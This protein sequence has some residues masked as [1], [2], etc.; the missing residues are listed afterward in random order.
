MAMKINIL[1]ELLKKLHYSAP[2]RVKIMGIVGVFVCLLGLNVIVDIRSYMSESLSDQL[3]KRATA[4]GKEVASESINL[5]LV[6]DIFSLYENAKSV[7][8]NNDDLRYVLILD[9]NG[10]LV[11]HTFGQGI[12]AGL[13]E[14]RDINTS[15][16]RSDV[17][18]IDSEEGVLLDV[19]VP[20]ADGK[21]GW[22]R[23]GMSETG[24][25][26][27]ID[28]LSAKLMIST[29]Q[30]TILG[31]VGAF[32]MSHLVTRPI[33]KLVDA[34]LAVAGGDLTQRVGTEGQDEIGQLNKTFNAMAESLELYNR[35]RET[36]VSELIKKEEVRKELLKKVITAQEEEQKRISREL[37]DETSQS[38]TSL[39]IGL[40]I[41]SQEN[42]IQKTRNMAEELR[43]VAAITLEEVHRLAVELRPTTLDDLGLIP[44]LE[45]YVA[46]YKRQDNMRMVDL[47]V[48]N[49]LED[50]LP[51]EME[52]TLY[53]IV[54]EAL[55]NVARYANARNV[56]IVLE[57][58]PDFVNLIVEDDGVGFDVGQVLQGRIK[59]RP[60][61]GLAG[62]QERAALL[63]GGLT[64]ESEPEKGT[65]VYVRLPLNWGGYSE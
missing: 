36:L 30:I 15:N 18:E 45:R 60:H 27:Q 34:S 51:A 65:A 53:R 49:K 3:E 40:R 21:A 29:I 5:I 58:R 22:V 32:I 46:D 63:G 31:L 10:Q 47:Q 2:L 38:L 57:I 54:Q 44:A 52:I 62:M 14:L 8:E 33:K 12:P 43:G 26:K 20:I 39:I 64:V 42:D 56:S 17:L 59:G 48:Q 28:D 6:G 4:I 7:V 19:M 24:M 35:E 13:L 41:L 23:V 9:Q 37:H 1:F 50:R 16:T 11:T 25:D 55:T 61:L